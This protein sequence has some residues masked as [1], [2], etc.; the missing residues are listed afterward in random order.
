M[1]ATRWGCF[2]AVLSLNKSPK[3]P[4]AKGLEPTVA[5]TEEVAEALAKS[6]L[7][8]HFKIYF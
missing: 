1:A 8:I 3:G 4:C 2:L 5:L 7:G 6:L